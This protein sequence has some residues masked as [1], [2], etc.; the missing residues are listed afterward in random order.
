MNHW[1]P[2]S[3]DEY[4]VLEGRLV[5][6]SH[7]KRSGMDRQHHRGSAR[8]RRVDVQPGEMR[9]ATA[10]RDRKAP[11]VILTADRWIVGA[12]YDSRIPVEIERAGIG[13]R[14]GEREI[15]SRFDAGITAGVDQAR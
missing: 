9:L 2:A 15:F 4:R 12:E 6:A 8:Q 10:G 5:L 3:F 14:H 1:P 7:G 13:E 11:V